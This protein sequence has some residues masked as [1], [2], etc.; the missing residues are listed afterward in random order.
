MADVA[1]VHIGENSPEQV[2]YKLMQDIA[3]CEGTDLGADGDR[4]ATREW[5]LTTFA[6]CLLTVRRPGA[7]SDH[8][9]SDIPDRDA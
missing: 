8:L 6:Q 9:K 3:K 2:A 4:A 1:M 5:V 7:V